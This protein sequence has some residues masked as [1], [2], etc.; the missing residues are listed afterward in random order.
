MAKQSSS[1]FNFDKYNKVVNA[2]NPG[3]KVYLAMQ[4]LQQVH[5]SLVYFNNPLADQCGEVVEIVKDFRTA[6]KAESA[7]RANP[8][9]RSAAT[10]NL[11]NPT[12]GQGDMAKQ[13]AEFQRFLDFQ[14]KGELAEAQSA[15]TSIDEIAAGVLH[16]QGDA[17][18]AA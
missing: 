9:E 17:V 6:Y 18:A 14:R 3:L 11:T 10:D 12:I 13:F 16:T 5:S 1:D 15:A 4:M 7:K 2:A 8:S